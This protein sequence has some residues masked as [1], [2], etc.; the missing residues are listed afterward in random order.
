MMSRLKQHSL[1]SKSSDRDSVEEDLS[2]RL[3]FLG[4][5]SVGKTSI[6]QRFLPD[7]SKKAKGKI[8][9][10]TLHEMYSGNLSF[11][12]QQSTGNVS[13][14]IEDTGADYSQSFPA[15]LEIS[16]R[17][18]D[19]VVLVFSVMDSASEEYISGLRET[20]LS[21]RPGLPIVI[22]GNKTEDEKA[23]TVRSCQEMEVIA[24]L[25]WEVGYTE[26]S[27]TSRVAHAGRPPRTHP[28]PSS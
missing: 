2:C 18:A 20:I 6:I 9:E 4:K 28:L 27:A 7:A 14:S 13:L 3:L 17:D 11:T 21:K 16:I 1:Y 19:V 26:C 24:C 12:S 22:V 5:G 10:R 8:P 15:M 25:D 23:R